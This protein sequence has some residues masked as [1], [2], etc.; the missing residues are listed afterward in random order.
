[1]TDAL[2]P[3]DVTYLLE[4]A[5]AKVALARTEGPKLGAWHLVD[6]AEA[7]VA[8]GRPDLA[9]A[10]APAA[11]P[12]AAARIASMLPSTEPSAQSDTRRTSK[13]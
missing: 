11:V 10:L 2:A 3:H 7:Y 1:M 8:A 6:A 13:R 9:A 5:A 4:C 12:E